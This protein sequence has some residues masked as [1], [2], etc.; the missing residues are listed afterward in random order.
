MTKFTAL[1]QRIVDRRIIVLESR[2]DPTVARLLGE[3]VKDRFFTSLRFLKPKPEEI[4]LISVDKYY[5][6]YIVVGGKY[7]I[8][9]CKK[10]VYS[11]SVDKNAREVAV[12]DKKF[13][14]EPSSQLPL[15]AH[16]I[17]VDGV[18]Y[19]HYEGEASLVLDKIG[20]EIDPEQLPCAPSEDR[21]VEELAST[22][23]KF[24]EVNISLE[25]EIEFL[26]SRIANHPSD[27][28]E[29]IREIFE[30]NE[31]T[32]IY[33]PMYQL[34]FRNV[35]NG[36]EA[37]AR[38]DGITGK[39]VLGEFSKTVLGEFR[40]TV[41]HKFMRDLIASD[42][43]EEIAR[44]QREKVKNRVLQLRIKL[45]LG[46]ITLV[47]GLLAGNLVLFHWVERIGLHYLLGHYARYV[48]AYGGFA[49]IIFGAM[50][51]NDFVFRNHVRAPRN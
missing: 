50:L 22:G 3:K 32:L 1:P 19:Y 49:A 41:P 14:P 33:C 21:T 8:D 42:G 47:V 27:V 35:K 7:S 6:P 31:R 48:C 28:G 39:T 12:F 38:I 18:A 45:I 43:P 37:I 25:E 44:A 29:V 20:R 23:I 34:G 26:S 10:R 5:E 9:Y 51:I 24:A 46:L 17:K 4:R 11:V 13:L 40:K 16:V 15:A 30:I 2:F 36:K